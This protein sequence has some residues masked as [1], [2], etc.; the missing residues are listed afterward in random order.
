MPIWA[1]QPAPAQPLPLRDVALFSSGVGYFHRAGRINGDAA[2]DLTF[3]PEQ[4]NDILKSLVLLDPKGT[5]RPV[6]YATQTPGIR[7]L[8]PG[9]RPIDGSLSLGSLLRGFQGAQVELQVN[10]PTGTETVQGRIVSVSLK[11]L[12]GGTPGTA[13]VT[14]EVLNVLGTEGLRA[15][16]LDS[17][18]Q[19]K[20]L[21]ERLDRELRSS[22]ETLAT[23]L[24]DQ[25]RPVSLRFAGNGERDVQAAY[26]QEMPIWKT[27]YRLVLDDK[28][29]PYL[30]GWGHIENTTD[31]DWKD[32]RLS[33]VSGRPVSFI[34]DLYQPLYIPRPVVQAQVIG[35]PTPQTY[36]ETLEAAGKPLTMT[37][38][39]GSFGAGGMGGGRTHFSIGNA[40]DSPMGERGPAGAPGA[41]GPAGPGVP[42]EVIDELIRQNRVAGRK[43]ASDAPEMSMQM[44]S[45]VAAQ[46]EGAERGEL[47][48]YAIKTP[49]TLP[50]GQAAMV[51]IVGTE[52]AG[53]RVSIFDV[54]ADTKHALNGFRLKNTSGLHLSG[55]PITVFQNDAYA[56]DAQ[57]SN[58]QPGEERLLSYAVDLELVA[59]R[60][61]PKV[62][63]DTL[64]ISAK[65]GVLVITRKQQRDQVYTFR[66]KSKEAKTVLVQQNIEPEF[67]LMEP[68]KPAE[69]TADEYRFLVTVPAEKTASLK[70]VSERPISEEIALFDA[71]IDFLVQFTRNGQVSAKLREA[72]TELV[73]KRR[74]ITSLQAQ[75]AMREG[76][77]KNIDAEQARIRQNMAQLD[78]NSPLYQ[79]YVTKLT[80]QETRIE[81]L[82]EEIAGLNEREAEAQ[83]ALRT[84]VDGLNVT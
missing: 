68:A 64:T 46:A 11:T 32:V 51:P 75:R 37:R 70:V 12:P 4:V 10:T 62:R 7:G 1:Q 81:K 27:S 25:R 41:P 24:N 15:V 77:I 23:G 31:E 59:D 49:V 39:P 33:L 43:A 35:S 26:L 36:G 34:Q 29:K 69:K 79:Q 3:R 8:G 22:L 63:Q 82:R 57:I 38:A 42:K 55:G 6:T 61:E 5:V 21:D 60:E 80:A 20:L 53:E 56:G 40:F 67:K 52:I 17:V 14:A 84:Y 76:E 18:G 54:D 16:S 2:I 65:S 9:G 66:N 58:L 19:V 44:A 73:A 48:E 78:R 13:P 50:R 28:G 30:Q 74:A 83:K 72:L 71:D 45:T 47:F